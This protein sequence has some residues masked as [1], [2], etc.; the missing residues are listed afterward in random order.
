[1][2]LGK[3]KDN[4]KRWSLRIAASQNKKQKQTTEEN[5]ENEELT[6]YNKKIKKMRQE[7]GEARVNLFKRNEAYRSY[8]YR[9]NMTDAEREAYN[10]KAKF[11]QRAYRQRQKDKGIYRKP[12][13]RKELEEIRVYNRQKKRESRRR[14]SDR[15]RQEERFLAHQNLLHGPPTSSDHDDMSDENDNL[16]QDGQDADTIYQK[17]QGMLK[18][19]TPK[20]KQMLAKKGICTP[21]SASTEQMKSQVVDGMVQESESLK[22]KRDSSSLVKRRLIQEFITSPFSSG[23]SDFG[24]LAFSIPDSDTDLSQV[25]NIQMVWGFEDGE[26][27]T[28]SPIDDGLVCLDTESDVQD[29][30][31]DDDATSIAREIVKPHTAVHIDSESDKSD[32]QD[33]LKDDDATSTPRETVEP[34]TAVHTDSERY[35]YGNC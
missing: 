32:V 3:G 21:N 26:Q 29:K 18:D 31:K 7:G 24:D 28:P 5:E 19:L 35:S 6:A 14:K 20:R 9:T 10:E 25:Q 34:H 11:R 1:M 2:T 13:T 30:L 23:D 16:E 22:K 27:R 4:N 12:R 33:K 15:Q 17:I 8:L